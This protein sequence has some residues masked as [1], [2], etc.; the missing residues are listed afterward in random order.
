MADAT[1]TGR[2]GRRRRLYRD[3]IALGAFGFLAL[4]TVGAILAPAVARHDPLKTSAR[5]FQ[6]PSAQHVLGTDYLGRDVLSRIVWSMRLSLLI[7]VVSA[8]IGALLGLGVGTIAGYLRGSVDAVLMRVTDGCLVLPTFFVVVV[9]V[10]LFGSSVWMLS[11]VI[12]LT[13]WPTVARLVRA[14]VLA[15]RTLDFVVAAEA[16]GASTSSILVRHIV[17]GTLALLL[18]HTSLRAGYAVVTEASL[19]FLGLGDPSGLSLGGMLTNTVQ[20]ARLAWWA[21]VFPGLAITA[22]VVAFASLGDALGGAFAI[23]RATE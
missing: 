4:M 10:A 3:P 12:G 21:A 2:R 1:S 22:L 13:N 17:P 23:G 11:V 15:L 5:V 14:E 18:V 8:L 6:S 20:F 7:A 16:L 19:G 9:V